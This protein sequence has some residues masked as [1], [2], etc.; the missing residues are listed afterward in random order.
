[1]VD[2]VYFDMDGVLFHFDEAYDR[3]V[4]KRKPN[5]DVFWHELAK[6][7]TFFRDLP[8]PGMLEMWN[9]VPAQYRR[10]LSSIP[11]SID[12]A[13]SQKRDCLHA[14]LDIPDEHIHLV[15]GKSLKKAFAR[16]GHVLVDDSPQNV[17]DW[18]E[19]GGI[20]ILHRDCYDTR[21]RLVGMVERAA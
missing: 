17:L 7:P 8:M 3:L 6:H 1:M 11:K 19:A 5:G 20:G 12:E 4:G 18:E 10:I 15:R 13:H 9:T 21:L 2:L 16:T 14:H